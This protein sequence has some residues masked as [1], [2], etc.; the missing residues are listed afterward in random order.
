MKDI[1]KNKAPQ[2]SNIFER[3]KDIEPTEVWEQSLF[4]KLNST[5]PA[6]KPG[7]ASRRFTFFMLLLVLFNAFFILSVL[8][9]QSP[10]YS[11]RVVTLEIISTELLVSIE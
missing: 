5:E 11:P 10:Q 2:E 8:K 9:K 3:L 4:Q 6:R 7:F 1:N